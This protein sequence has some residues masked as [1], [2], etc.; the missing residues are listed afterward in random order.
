M[1]CLTLSQFK[2]THSAGYCAIY[3][4]SL[5]LKI[6]EEVGKIDYIRVNILGLRPE[7]FFDKLTTKN[8]GGLPVCRQN[9]NLYQELMRIARPR[10][11]RAD[12][13]LIVSNLSA[14]SSYR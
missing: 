7:A 5:L 1:S 6:L 11:Q 8:N 2:W 13:D 4:F 14:G 12:D 10:I 3:S 9:K